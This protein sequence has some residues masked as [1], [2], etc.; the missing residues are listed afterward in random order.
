MKI[1]A[2]IPARMAVTRFPNKPLALIG[3]LPM[4][5]HVRRR[6]ALCK[7]LSDVIVATCD[8]EIMDVV[9]QNGG[10]AVMTS[11]QHERCTDRVAEAAAHYKAD[12]IVNVQGDEPLIHPRMIEEVVGPLL[13]NLTL[14]CSNLM[15]RI[16]DHQEFK[17]VNAVKVVCDLESNLLYA[18]REAIP[19]FSKAGSTDY[20]KWKQLGIIA[21]KNDFLQIFSK[22]APTPLEII[23]SVDMNRALEH[24][25]KIRMVETTGRMIGV[26]I[27]EQVKGIEELL[28]KDPLVKNYM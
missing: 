25:Y 21:F 17:D 20:A 28:A 1:I 6:V 12:I 27:P 4:I 11:N 10:K 9:I 26:D 7:L 23:E 3:G 5:E 13:E 14:P 8:Q 18:S 2:I 24:G 22:L 16:V 15:T 19:S